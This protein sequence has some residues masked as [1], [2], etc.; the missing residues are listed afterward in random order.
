MIYAALEISRY[1]RSSALAAPPSSAT[2]PITGTD[3]A[4]STSDPS[5]AP[6]PPTATKRS[7]K[8]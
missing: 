7:R 8:Q 5:P 1:L 2:P 6:P 4:P 3:V